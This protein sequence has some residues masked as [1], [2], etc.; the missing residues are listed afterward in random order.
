MLRARE[1]DGHS[2]EIMRIEP[3][4]YGTQLEKTSNQQSPTYEQHYSKR[5][6]GDHQHAS[7]T[8]ASY[9]GCGATFPILERLI[10]ICPSVLQHRS[11][12]E[13]QSGQHRQTKRE[14]ENG[15]V[16]TDVIDA[17]QVWRSKTYQ[18]LF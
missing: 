6:F 9:P 12:T 14:K 10:E 17:R 18:R 4:V 13:E 16:K 5:H 11:K 2:E 7:Q 3:R 1:W 8:L 15:Q